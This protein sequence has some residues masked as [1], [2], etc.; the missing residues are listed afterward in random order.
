MK[1]L[2]KTKLFTIFLVVSLLVLTLSQSAAAQ[3][4]DAMQTFF[5]E[6]FPG[7]SI[8]VNA[9]REVIPEQNI[10]ISLWISCRSLDVIMRDLNMSVYGFRVG[11]EK[12]LLMNITCISSETPLTFNTTIVY[13]CTAYVSAE[14][15]DTTYTEL[16]FSYKIA[17]EPHDYNQNFSMTHVRN[18]YLENLEQ[19]LRDL[20]ESFHE[21]NNTYWQLNSTY[22][23]LNETY[24]QLQQRYNSSQVSIIELDN[25]RRASAILVI[26]T[27]FFIASTMYLILRKPREYW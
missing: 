8:G 15:W 17:N 5:L 19:Q 26:T 11:R 18:V 22:M 3:T 27:V 16:H 20:N 14:I 6:T 13:N 1:N 7:V 10:T 25:M 21:L 24:W 2:K 4:V 23:Q 12:T 9:S